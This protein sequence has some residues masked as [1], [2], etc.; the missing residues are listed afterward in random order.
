MAVV[1]AMVAVVAMAVVATAVSAYTVQAPDSPTDTSQQAML[2]SAPGRSNQVVS[3]HGHCS[4]Q[5]IVLL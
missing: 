4:S 1:V 5:Y 2:L 3:F